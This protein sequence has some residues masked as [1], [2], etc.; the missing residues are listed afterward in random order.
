LHTYDAM[1][2]DRPLAKA[3]VAVLGLYGYCAGAQETCTSNLGDVTVRGGLN[4]VARCQLSGTDV[5]GDVVLFEGGSLIARDARIRGKLE[6]SRADFVAI[7]RSRV[8]GAISLQALVGNESTIERSDLR[9]ET[10]LT[11]NRSRLRILNNDF[12]RSLEAVGNTGGVE[13]S[14]NFIEGD[15]RC[16]RNQPAPIVLANRIEGET[17]GQCAGSE[18][19]PSPPAP[20][21]PQAAPSPTPTPASPSPATPSSPT[22]SPPPAPAPTPPTAS[23]PAPPPA[24]SPP[25]TTTAPPTTPPAP[26]PPAIDPSLEDEG[27]GA[28]ALGWP[29]ALLLLLVARRRSMT[30]RDEAARS[31]AQ[32][33]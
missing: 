16:A 29:T 3:A 14:G 32:T 21:P 9:G 17:Q 5:R 1:H 15:L 23:P 11:G 24:S 10:V 22:S 12:R 13:I 7:E 27:G 19:A 31:R 18:P 30:R 4:V 28:G 25:P 33:P 8:D 2:Q 26:T 6:G 20:E